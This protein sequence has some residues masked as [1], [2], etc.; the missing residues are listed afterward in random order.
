[1]QNNSICLCT[2]ARSTCAAAAK[3]SCE[4]NVKSPADEGRA[5]K[6]NGTYA[7]WGYFWPIF[8]S[9]PASSRAILSLCRQKITSVRTI[10]S[11][12]VDG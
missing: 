1:M 9:V 10:E 12:T 3:Q 5:L 8:G 11:A 2:D 4:R 7:G 6:I